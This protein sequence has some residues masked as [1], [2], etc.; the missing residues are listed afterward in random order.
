MTILL[1]GKY[2]TTYQPK[3]KL[4]YRLMFSKFIHVPPKL[5]VQCLHNTCTSIFASIFP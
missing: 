1:P 5:I 3:Y 2:G 4:Y